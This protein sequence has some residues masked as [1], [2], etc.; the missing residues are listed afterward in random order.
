MNLADHLPE[1]EVEEIL[2]EG[3]ENTME[4]KRSETK[5]GSKV[6]K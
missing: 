4:Q 1:E 3:E 5:Y 6:E 2:E